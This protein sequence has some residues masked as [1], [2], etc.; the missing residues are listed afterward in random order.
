MV[1]ALTKLVA[2]L[3]GGRPGVGRVPRHGARRADPQRAPLRDRRRGPARRST[4]SSSKAWTGFDL[5][6][7]LAEALG[8]P[9][10]V[11]NDA[12]VQGL[13]GR[14]RQGSRAGDH[15]RDRVRHRASSWTGTCCPTSRSPISRSARARPTTTSWGSAT[16]KE[17]GDDALEPPGPQGDRGARPAALLRPP[18]HRRRQRPAGHARRAGR[19]F[20][21]DD[22]GGQL[23]GHSGRDQALGGP[24]SA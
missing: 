16:R 22:G 17:I 5:A 6:G 7:A 9:T 1:P 20:G 14:R 23:G 15:A 3:P 4:R 18:L 11:A 13:G 12:D 8:K 19:L 10:K 2:P 24:T 21:N